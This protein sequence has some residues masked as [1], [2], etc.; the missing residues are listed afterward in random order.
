MCLIG[1]DPDAED[2]KRVRVLRGFTIFDQN[3]DNLMLSLDTLDQGNRRQNFVATGNATTY[4]E[5]DEDEGQED[6]DEDN[7]HLDFIKTDFIQ[8][9]TFDYLTVNRSVSSLFLSM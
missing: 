4:A 1:E 8:D 6:E 7:A 3:K 2:G 9:W 5:V